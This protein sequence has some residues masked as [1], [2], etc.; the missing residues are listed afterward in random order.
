MPAPLQAFI[1]IFFLGA[2][3]RSSGLLG[4]MH[5]ERLASFVFSISLPATILVSLD[6]VTFTPTAWKLPLAAC[7]VTLSMLLCS[8]QV[9]RRLHVPRPTQGG[10]LLGTG[11]INSVYFAYPVVLATF[12]DQGLAR[13]V[14]FDLGQTTLTLTDLRHRRRTRRQKYHRSLRR[15]PV[16][17][18]SAAMGALLQP[19]AFAIRRSSSRLG[20]PSPHASP[21]HHN[22]LG[23]PRAGTLDQFRRHAPHLG[24]S[25]A[26]RPDAHG[27]RAAPW[28]RCCLGAEPHRHRTNHR[29]THRRHAL[30]RHRRD[31]R[32][33]HS[34]G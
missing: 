13:A 2:L 14:L 15:G 16:R 25:R 11:C 28:T 23:K 6:H 26:R 1:A 10:F 34:S 12:G 29:R 30:R 20:S 19:P 3:L 32:R 5:A 17:S 24:L 31:L 8:W 33:G 22:P 7:L 18:I 21:P 9:A 4:K 27:G